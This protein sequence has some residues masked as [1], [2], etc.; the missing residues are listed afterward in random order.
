MAVPKDKVLAALNKTFQGKS[1]SKT[2]KDSLATKWAAKI[3][4]EED[5]DTYVS[6]R[7][8]DI[9]EAS[10]EAD[11]RAL[12]AAKTAKQEAADAVAGKK[13]A[14]EIPDEVNK[15]VPEWMKPFM[16]SIQTLATEVQGLKTQKSVETLTDRFMKEERLKTVPDFMKKMAVPKT[17][18]DFEAA[19]AGLSTEFTQFATQ[20]KI[21]SFGNDA[22]GGNGNPAPPAAQKVDPAIVAFAA[23]KVEEVKS[24]QKT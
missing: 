15:D 20:H 13:Q 24:T 19:V 12:T 6:D 2:Y 8:D 7:E 17:E 5:I 11:R 3:E 22:P 21:E 10:A 1:V 4:N 23:R 18:D 14:G 16:T 9:L